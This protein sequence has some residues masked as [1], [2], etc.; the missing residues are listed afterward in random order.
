MYLALECW[1]SSVHGSV[2]RVL[3]VEK[4]LFKRGSMLGWHGARLSASQEWLTIVLPFLAVHGLPTPPYVPLL[5]ASWSLLD[6]IWGSLKGSWGCWYGDVE[7]IWPFKPISSEQA[8][9]AS[10]V[11][12]HVGF[13]H[14]QAR[15]MAVSANWG[16]FRRVSLL[17]L[18][19]YY[20]GSTLEPLTFEKLPHACKL[21]A[22][23]AGSLARS[24]PQ[25]SNF[26]ISLGYPNKTQKQDT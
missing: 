2:A 17:Y 9:P 25:N 13:I 15:H 10:R 23:C 1:L 16:S 6:G 22:L 18:E 19:P 8:Q 3:Q 20:L 11:T 26:S 21:K 24:R 5:R 4:C 12:V 14:G 7:G